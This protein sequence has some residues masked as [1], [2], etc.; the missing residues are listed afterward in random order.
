MHPQLD[1]FFAGVGGYALQVEVGVGL[2]IVEVLVAAPVLPTLVPPLEKDALDVVGRG[3]VDVPQGVFGGGAVAR[4][5]GPHLRA[6]VHAPPDADILLRLDPRGVGYLG[7]LV[8][9]ENQRRVDEVHRLVAQ[10]DGA[11]RSGEASGDVGLDAVGQRC[12]VGFEHSLGIAPQHH[13]GIIVERRFVDRAIGALAAAER[14]RRIGVADPGDRLLAVLELVGLEIAGDG[15]RHGR[16]LV[17]EAEFGELV[18]HG[19]RIGCVE[20]VAERHA[21]VV[22]PEPQAEFGAVVGVVQLDGHFVVAVAVGLVLA[23]RLAPLPVAGGVVHD[24]EAEAGEIAFLRGDA[25]GRGA[26]EGVAVAQNGVGH[27]R[28]VER[29]AVAPV[30]REEGR[31][32]G[33][34]AQQGGHASQGKKSFHHSLGRSVMSKRTVAPSLSWE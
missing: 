26:D 13:L 31:G 22:G 6:E 4:A 16:L 3:E 25:E 9:V 1:P 18:R 5:H 12:E 15:P 20:F 27:R 2:D 21:V 8:E 29:H 24:P 28:G 17:G 33:A 34:G 11:P 32:G 14:E 10:L 30:G 23:P 7:G 19:E